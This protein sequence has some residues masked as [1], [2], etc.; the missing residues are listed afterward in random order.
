MGLEPT[1][2]GITIR[3]ATVAP[4]TPLNHIETL[5]LLPTLLL[6]HTQCFLWLQPELFIELIRFMDLP[7]GYHYFTGWQGRL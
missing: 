6:E 5:C 4:P 1:T 3:C 7:A 2:N